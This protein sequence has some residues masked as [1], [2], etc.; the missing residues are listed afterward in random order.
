MI[1]VERMPG[2]AMA[3]R[4]VEVVER[5]GLGHPDTI[6]DGIMEAVS[7]ALNNVYLESFGRVLHNNIDKGL[8]IAGQ[9]EKWFGGGRVVQPMEVIIGDRATSRFGGRIIPVEEIA[10]AAARDWID[11]HLPQVRSQGD[12]RIR[13]A[14]A[15]ASEELA[16]LFERPGR[17]LPANDTSAAV[18]YFPLTPTETAVLELETRLNSQAFKQRYPETAE[19][20]KVMGVRRGRS[21]DLTVAMPLLSTHVASETE[22]FARKE[23]IR[24]DM[25]AWAAE[26]LAFE[27]AVQFNAL[28]EPGRGLQGVYLSLL[29]TSAED[30]DSGQVGRGNRVNGLIPVNRPIGTEAVCG[31]NPVSHTGKIYNVLA[32]RAARAIGEQ[33]SGVREVE[34]LLVSRIGQSVDRPLLAA[35]RLLPDREGD[36]MILQRQAQAILEAE[37]AEAEALCRRLC[38]G[39]EYLG[40][41]I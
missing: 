7:I 38:R 20:V 26:R 12:V 22:Y 19:D 1:I 13:V 9:V 4:Q 16:G 37:L 18:G 5:K 29:G 2:P 41:P 39:K 10:V 33:L 28:D 32:H 23:T 17:L 3:D 36:F 30:A 15:P 6:C 40:V 35:V 11:R 34:V 21:L 25:A 8:L 24:R 27:V 31:K 14:L